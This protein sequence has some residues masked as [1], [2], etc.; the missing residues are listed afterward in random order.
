METE[1]SF[2]RKEFALLSSS[3]LL[4]KYHGYTHG[5]WKFPGQGPNLSCSHSRLFN[6]LCRAGDR[7]HTSPGTGATA[8]GFL[9]PCAL[10]RTP[11]L[12]LSSLPLPPPNLSAASLSF[13]LPIPDAWSEGL[14][15]P[16]PPR[17]GVRLFS[18]VLSF[19]SEFPSL[20]LNKD[21]N[22]FQKTNYGSWL[23]DTSALLS[24]PKD[25]LRG[26]SR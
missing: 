5:I 18:A 21:T 15:S 26:H 24:Q 8:V 4:K 2:T 3:S 6:P 14:S 20:K 17:S 11:C 16:C 25:G 7:T 23:G 19:C 9:T 1:R 22:A 12:F 13:N 10:A